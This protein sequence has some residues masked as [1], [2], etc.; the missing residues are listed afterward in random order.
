MSGEGCMMCATHRE[1]RY[2]CCTNRRGNE[3]KI[4]EGMWAANLFIGNLGEKSDGF[5]KNSP[6]EVQMSGL[7]V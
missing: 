4:L 7:T 2:F 6:P 5:D 1:Y 3:M